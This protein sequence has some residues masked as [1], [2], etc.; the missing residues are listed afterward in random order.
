VQLE[1]AA[2][3]TTYTEGNI[4]LDGQITF[5]NTA[6]STTAFQ[7]QD[8]SAV[9]LFAVD[10]TGR[11]I[12]ISGDTTTFANLTL[13][14]AHFKSTQTTAPTIGT[15]SNC[16]TSPT[17]A[18]A[19]NST[20]SAGSFR[21]TSGTGGGQTTCD[22]IVTFNKAFGAAPKSIHIQAETQDGG[23]GTS[24]ARQIYVSATATTTF[25][26][27]MNS[28]PAGASE[29]DWFYYWVVE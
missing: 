5:K 9:S 23:T 27:K 1:Q 6:N 12:T 28:P 2:A 18:V 25:T 20:D 24:A 19:S 29:V 11:V 10:T 22:T 13:T 8:A 21:I 7:I 4:K 17:A 14:N 3:A 16:A 15:P 26:V